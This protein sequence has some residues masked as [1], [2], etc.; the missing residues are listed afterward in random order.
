MEQ[1][2][3]DFLV[4]GGGIAG[5]SVGAWLAGRGRTLVLERETQPGYHATGRSA[6]LYTEHYGNPTVRALTRASGRFLKAPPPGFAEHPILT[7]RG[8]LFVARADQ[9]HRLAA[10][11]KEMRAAGG[12]ARRLDWPDAMKIVPILSP[13]YGA[14]ALLDAGAMDIDV[15]ALLQGYLRALRQAGGVLVT[16]AEVAALQRSGGIWRAAT[17]DRSYAAPVVINAAGAWAD[18]IAGLAGLPPL[19]IAPLRRSVAVLD[20]PSG[21]EVSGWPMFHDVEEKF[22]A[23]ADAGRLLISPADETP[24]PPCDAQAEDLDLAIAVDRLERAT[25]LKVTRLQRRWAGL[26]SFAPDRTP[27]AGFD[28]LAEGF[29]W[30]AGQGGYG[31]QTSA[32]LGRIAA[33]L[34]EGETLPADIA[35]ESISAA[36]LSPARLR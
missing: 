11:E 6:A 33:A 21:L 34:A 26:R 12:A 1:S 25:T 30:L 7:P 19:G 28:P 27:V 2:E 32:A 15:H 4:I 22:Y 29:F 14:A 31:I 9:I 17:R 5:I 13:D 3:A 36:D 35:G 23:K 18:T 10:L 24:S 20:L 16:D 8:V